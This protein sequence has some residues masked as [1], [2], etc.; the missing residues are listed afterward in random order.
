[1]IKKDIILYALVAGMI[2]S[3]IYLVGVEYHNEQ[4]MQIADA[5]QVAANWRAL[6]NSE[7]NCAEIES[8]MISLALEDFAGS[9]IIMNA[10]EEKSQEMEC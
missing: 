1:M 7:T 9:E 6:P 4:N 3:G 5:Q 10:L 2:G 8:K